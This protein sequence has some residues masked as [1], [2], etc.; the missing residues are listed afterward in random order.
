MVSSDDVVHR[1][2][3]TEEVARAVVERFGGGVLVD[4]RIDRARLARTAFASPDGAAALE[5]LLHPL[6]GREVARWMD[7]Q[8]RRS[9]PPPVL[10]NEVPLLFEAGLE[11]RFDRTLVV[12]AAEDLRRNRLAARGD[13][14]ALEQREARLLSPAEKE[15]RADDVLVN[16]GSLEDL[17]RAVGEYVRRHAGRPCAG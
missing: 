15:A 11:G 1:L 4:G 14:A 2:L 17:D 5:A 12:R 6:V 3:S 9:P 16:D 7:E 13:L 8:G 10:V